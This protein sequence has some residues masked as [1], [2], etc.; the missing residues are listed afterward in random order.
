MIIAYGWNRF[1][2]HDS[3]QP[4]AL[5]VQSVCGL[6]RAGAGCG[7]AQERQQVPVCLTACGS[8]ADNADWLLRLPMTKAV[9]RAMDTVTDFVRGR[10]SDQRQPHPEDKLPATCRL[11]GVLGHEGRR[12]RRSRS[13]S[14]WSPAPPSVA[15]PPG[16]PA[17]STPGWSGSS[18][19]GGGRSIAFTA[20][21]R[22]FSSFLR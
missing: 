3:E 11:T 5:S 18:R 19:C 20:S 8:T 1:L 22:T 7:D 10:R 6:W 2:F 9:A 16:Q 17:Q 15:G 4:P 13:P 14:L 12:R 21:P